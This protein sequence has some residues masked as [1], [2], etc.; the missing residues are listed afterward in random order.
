MQVLL[1]EFGMGMSYY[2]GVRVQPEP[3]GVAFGPG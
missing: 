2:C 3:I 1:P